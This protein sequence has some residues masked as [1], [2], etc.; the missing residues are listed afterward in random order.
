MHPH[1]HHRVQ[2]PDHRLQLFRR[3]RQAPVPR[4]QARVQVQPAGVDPGQPR[5]E[6]VLHRVVP[7]PGTVLPLAGRQEHSQHRRQ[8]RLGCHRCHRGQVRLCR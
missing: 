3:C 6:R 1:G 7:A 8:A 5:L 4:V 2:A